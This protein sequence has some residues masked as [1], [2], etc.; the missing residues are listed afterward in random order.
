MTLAEKYGVA[1][2]VLMVVQPDERN[3]FD[4]RWLEFAL[5]ETHGIKLLRRSLAA[6]N[7]SAEFRSDRAMVVDGH[8]VWN[9]RAP[10]TD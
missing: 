4:Q 10:A 7:A 5:W 1:G 2:S 8:Q 6:I 3:S 9:P